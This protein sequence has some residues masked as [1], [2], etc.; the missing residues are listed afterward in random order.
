[1]DENRLSE[2]KARLL[3]TRAKLLDYMAGQ[4]D[5]AMI[6][7]GFLSMVAGVQA[8]LQAVEEEMECGRETPA[9][10]P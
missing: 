7:P 9:K 6:E 5:D 10:S 3:E 1:M 8:A 4:S 2:L